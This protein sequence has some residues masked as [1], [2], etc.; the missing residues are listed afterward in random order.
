MSDKIHFQPQL[1]EL[2]AGKGNLCC[3]DVIKILTSL[4]FQVRDGKKGGHKIYTHDGIA[5]FNSS[6]F[7]CGHGKNPEIKQPYIVNI[8]RVI[9][10]NGVALNDYLKEV[11]GD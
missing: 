5:D 1:D 8:M 4:G 3:S 9:K 6:S 2:Q 10:L 11:D 7:N